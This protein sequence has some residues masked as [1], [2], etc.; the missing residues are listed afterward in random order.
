MAR[1]GT[2]LERGS[3]CPPFGFGTTKPERRVYQIIRGGP[4][5]GAESTYDGDPI[6]N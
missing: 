3:A 1:A 4:A 5:T 2:R 6:A